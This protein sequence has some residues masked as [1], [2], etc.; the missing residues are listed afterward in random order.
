MKK[1]N[2]KKRI[3]YWVCEQM[4]QAGKVSL[5]KLEIDLHFDDCVIV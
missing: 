1:T 3:K 5:F 4:T 2:G